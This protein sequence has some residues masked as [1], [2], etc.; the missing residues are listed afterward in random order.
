MTSE[1]VFELSKPQ[2]YLT[3]LRKSLILNMAG[4]GSGKTLQIGVLSGWM[5][6]DYPLAK[7]FIAANTDM[8]LTQS[9]LSRVTQTWNSVFGLTE[10][11]AKTNPKGHFVID[12]KPPSHFKVNERLKSYHNAISFYNGGLIYIGSLENYKAHDGKEFSWAHLDET[13]DTRKEALSTVILARLRQVALWYDEEGN[14]TESSKPLANHTAWNPCYIHTSPAEGGVDWIIE[15]FNLDEDEKEIRDRLFQPRHF[16]TKQTDHTAVIIHQTYWNARN[17]PPNHFEMQQARMTEDEQLKYLM[18]YPFAKSGG[19]FFPYFQRQKHVVPCPVTLDYAFHISYDFNVVPYLTQILFQIEYRKA[20][21]DGVTRF[22]D[23][24]EGLEPIEVMVMKAVKEY[25]MSEPLNTTEHASQAFLD[26]FENVN[27]DIFVYGDASGRNRI[28][29]L[30]S[31][32]QYYYI[33][34]V[35]RGYLPNGWMRVPRANVGILKRRDFINRIFDNK[36]PFL[37]IEVDPS[38]KELIRDLEFL[39]LGPNGKL[40]EKA[41]DKATG[42]VYEKIGHMSDAFEYFICEVAKQYLN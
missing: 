16:Y 36:Y 5:I 32:T 22:E 9:T 39:K 20:W 31:K 7:G 40:K 27:P 3:G 38:C 8:Q 34:K 25:A 30:G 35:L 11:D 4:Q 1:Q 41:K 19:E 10:Y 2:L 21:W 42:A 6:R 29:G 24:D 15:M 14:I 33:E 28:V 13:K 23:E 18:G 37:K 12:K 26:D 17:L